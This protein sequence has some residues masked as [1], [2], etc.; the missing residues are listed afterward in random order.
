MPACQLLYCPPPARHKLPV[1]RGGSV[2]EC[3]G[4]LAEACRLSGGPGGSLSLLNIPAVWIPH[5]HGLCCL[6]GR[7]WACT[8][9]LPSLWQPLKE[10]HCGA[11]PPFAA[12]WRL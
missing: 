3:A 2:Q 10:L 12:C 5:I 11:G 7:T 4:V 1:R 6:L 8:P 9:R